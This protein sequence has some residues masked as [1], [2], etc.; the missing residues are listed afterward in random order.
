MRQQTKK[1]NSIDKALIILSCF[2]PYNQEMG[3]VEI[4]Q[5]LGFHKATV[6]RILLNLARHGF[7]QQNPRTKKFILGPSILDLA[8]AINQTL[9]NN[10]VYIAKPYI[11]SLRDKLK[12]VVILEALSGRN[13]IIAYLA[14]G[15][16]PVRLAGTVGDILPLH[17]A[18]GAKAILAFSSHAKRDSLLFGTLARF[19]PNTITDPAILRAQLQDIRRKGYSCDEEGHDVGINAVGAPIFNYDERPVAAV[20][21]AG[22][23]QRVTCKSDSPVIPLLKDTAAKISAQLYYKD[24]TTIEG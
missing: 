8:R 3:T 6:S 14:K 22:P 1:S 2:S 23:S 15:S 16:R 21:V 20:V 7:I 12:D 19:T 5:K 11:D 13:T 10:L 9:S 4:S 17:V 24:S 18:A